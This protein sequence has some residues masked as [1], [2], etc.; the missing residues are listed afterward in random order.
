M[1]FGI[2]GLPLLPSFQA[3]EGSFR[4]YAVALVLAVFLSYRCQ[5]GFSHT[6]EVPDLNNV[7]YIT[8]FF[9]KLWKNTFF[10]NILSQVNS[11]II[12]TYCN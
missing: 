2:S 4:S 9:E 12:I 7:G 8:L 1:A 3:A 6:Q 11:W 10:A 5:W